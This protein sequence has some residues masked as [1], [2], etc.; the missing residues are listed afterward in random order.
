MIGNGQTRNREQV[1]GE[2]NRK[3]KEQEH[4]KQA[5]YNDDDD[6]GGG[7]FSNKQAYL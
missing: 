3:T 4:G 7:L 6:D 1:D 2:E 5:C